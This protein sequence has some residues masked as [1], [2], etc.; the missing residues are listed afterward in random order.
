MLQ[1][2][3]HERPAIRR[4]AERAGCAQQRRNVRG[5]VLRIDARPDLA[6]H[7]EPVAADQHGRVGRSLDRAGRSADRGSMTLKA[8]QRKQMRRE[9]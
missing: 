2:G 3:H 9:P 7:D 4:V 5:D 6:I 1:D 8:V